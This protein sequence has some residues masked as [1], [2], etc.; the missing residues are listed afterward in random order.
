MMTFRLALELQPPLAAFAVMGASMAESSWC[1]PASRPVSALIIHGTDDPL[2]PYGGGAVAPQRTG[3]GRTLPIEQVVALWCRVDSISGSPV[4]QTLP[5]RTG[6][7][8]PTR[9]TR[10]L[11]PPGAAGT[12][13]EL[14]R[15]QGGGHAEP[16]ISEQNPFTM[17]RYG[18]QSHDFE[19]AEEAWRFFQ[20]ARTV[21][22]PAR[23][24][25]R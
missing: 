22:P 16:S 12:R 14:M 4:E 6:G 15:I 1:L 18:P 5:H 24:S 3:G 9:T 2:V 13:V 17:R 25:D 20:S 8:D 19:C 7:G 21:S 11:Y 10:I 23:S